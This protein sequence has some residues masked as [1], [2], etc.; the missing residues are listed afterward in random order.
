MQQARS[1]RTQTMCEKKYSMNEKAK[2]I[3]QKNKF[4]RRVLTK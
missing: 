3:K 4:I 2:K 1:K